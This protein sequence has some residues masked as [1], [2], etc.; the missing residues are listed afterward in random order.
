[1]VE[2]QVGFHAAVRD[3]RAAIQLRQAHCVHASP[4]KAYQT[5]WSSS[6]TWDQ[7]SRAVLAWRAKLARLLGDAL[8]ARPDAVPV[9]TNALADH[10]FVT[11]EGA[12]ILAR[13]IPR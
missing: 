11:F 8:A 4:S 3:H 1:V 6:G 2:D 5:I 12:F 10:V 7:I 9:D 13:S